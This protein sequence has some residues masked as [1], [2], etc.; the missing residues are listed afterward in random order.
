ME[1]F[2][3]MYTPMIIKWKKLHYSESELV[4]PTLYRRLI[5]SLMYLVNTKPDIC[6]LCQLTKF[7]VEPR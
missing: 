3:P 6:F 7:M 1:D 4:D 2:R 5:V